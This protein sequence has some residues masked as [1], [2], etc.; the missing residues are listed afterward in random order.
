MSTLRIGC[1]TLLWIAC[2]SPVA[3]DLPLVSQ[4]QAAE[5]GEKKTFVYK[6][7]GDLPI[8]LDAYFSREGTDEQRPL[9]VHIHGGALIMGNRD[10]V[11]APVLK[12]LLEGGCVVVS[13]DYRLAPETKLPEIIADIEDAFRWLHGPGA[14]ELRIDPDRIAV[15][16]GSAGG[17]L[18]L[19]TGH[20]VQPPPRALVSFW[21]YGN[22]LDRWYTEPSLHARHQKEGLTE[23]I[24]RQQVSGR[25]VSDA[26]ERKSN[27][28]LFYVFCRQQGIWPREVTG[29][30]PVRDAEKFVPYLPVRNVTANYPPT[31]LIHGTDDTDVP[32]EESRLMAAQ[33]A[34]QGVEHRLITVEGGEHGLAGVDKAVIKEANDAAVRFMLNRL[35]K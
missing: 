22:L 3:P 15:F 24:A 19:I 35:V 8:R 1:W 31:L 18:T 14:K 21:G 16:G 5:P 27:S 17:Y 2:L 6:S 4:G 9:A 28:G 26:R 11:E 34:K 25:P 30:D 23:E 12:G 7:V 29:W 10:W 33:L 13:L 20:R 32:F